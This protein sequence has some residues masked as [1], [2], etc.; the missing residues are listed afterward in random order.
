MRLLYNCVFLAGFVLSAPYYFWRL[1]RRGNWVAGFGQRFGDYDK[2]LRQAL[3]NRH[4]VWVHAVSVGEANVCIELLKAL[5]TAAPNAKLVV[6][7][8]T[9]TGMA[10]LQKRLPATVS[11]IYYPID[12]R[13]YVDLAFRAIH[14]SAVIIVETEIWPNF[15]WRA[16]D[17]GTPLFLVN[18]RL[19]ER[20]YRRYRRARFLFRDLFASFAG[21]A[22]QTEDYARQFC[23]LGCV[24]DAVRVT[25]NIKFDAVRS[26]GGKLVDVAGLLRQAGAP[27]NAQILVAGSTHAGEE[28]ILARI[29]AR[30]RTRFPRLFLVVVPRH[31]ERAR[32]AARSVEKHLKVMLRTEV[33]ADKPPR[34]GEVECLLVNT[35][36]ELLAFYQHATLAFVGKSLAARG[37]QNPIEPAALGVPA[38]FGPHMQNFA[39]V[40][41]TLATGG[42]AI[43]VANEAELEQAF[44]RLLSDEGYRS[45]MGKKGLSIVQENQG[46][47]SR[48][49]EMILPHLARRGFFLAP[50]G[51]A[52]PAAG[53]PAAARA[54]GMPLP[55]F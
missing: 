39:D 49:L 24:P 17:G 51:P 32:D 6:S 13:K 29:C 50:K 5:Q 45:A 27:E 8:T 15:I 2:N 46:T 48:T 19:S 52:A 7:T 22:A 42:G 16:R 30:L 18:A 47:V 55:V 35:T 38:V 34:P 9:T 31:F 4:V 10:E 33:S 12:R 40:A 25:G 53:E 20:S 41:R 28:E 43:Q 44:S 54:Q 11:K 3:T 26:G 36:G 1:W 21:V 37:G 23:E 14:P